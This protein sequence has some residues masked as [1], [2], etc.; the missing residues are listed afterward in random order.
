MKLLTNHVM[1][2]AL[3]EFCQPLYND[4]LKHFDVQ[5]WMQYFTLAVTFISQPGLQLENFRESKRE[6]ILEK[7]GDMRLTMGYQ[8]LQLWTH[9]NDD[10][11][12]NFIPSSI[13]PF[14]EVTMISQPE[15]RLVTLQTFFY[16]MMQTEFRLNGDIKQTESELIDRYVYAIIFI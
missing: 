9:L 8:M 14:L 7:Y 15:L 11:K 10:Q 16:D 2:L 6:W 12:R 13:G 5:L 3:Q 1:L 4:F